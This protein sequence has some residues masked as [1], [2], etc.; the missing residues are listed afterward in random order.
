MSRDNSM[1]KE[2]FN[3]S[4]DY[5]AGL[6]VDATLPSELELSQKWGV[7]RTT[8]R[9]VLT[10][11]NETKVIRWDGRRKTV[12]RK[13]TKPDYF[14]VEETISTAERVQTQ[15]MEYI[16]G[17][18]LKPG[19][20][21]R[22]SELVRS[23]GASTS[24]VR[25]LLIRFSRFGLI[26]KE[27]NRH[28]ELR[29]FTRDFAIE[30]ADVREMFEQRAF[31]NMLAAGA[32]S[33]L[34]NALLAL[35]DEHQR[36]IDRIDDAY[37]SFP[38]LDEQFHRTMIDALSNRFIV[39]FFELV[40]VIFHYHYRWNKLDEHERNLAAAQQHLQ[41]IHALKAGDHTAASAAFKNHLQHARATLLASVSW[42]S[43]T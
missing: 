20:V 36:I 18:D 12:L 13:P 30:L 5:V 23:F 27:R 39:D 1:Y 34:Q 33:E 8:V 35:E 2:S 25:E 10:H 21:L 24:V 42:E 32:G 43:D 37:L 31:D 15:F 29:G 6:G 4:L 11:L 19:T 38:R 41:V 17:S 3:R 40:S 7:S 26:E 28:W 16:L 14:A 22:E 9:A